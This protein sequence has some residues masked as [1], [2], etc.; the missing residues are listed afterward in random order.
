[1]EELH[2]RN[3]LKRENGNVERAARALGV[4]RSSLY[5]KLKIYRIDR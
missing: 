3:V 2:I 5:Q 1:M 4:S